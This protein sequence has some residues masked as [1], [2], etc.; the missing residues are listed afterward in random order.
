MTAD[1]LHR[2]GTKNSAVALHEAGHVSAGWA[3]RPAVQILHASIAPP[4]VRTRW[5]TDVSDE[6]AAT[7]E[8]LILID[9]AGG[10]AEREA[11][12]WPDCHAISADEH[13]ATA[14]AL[15][16][17]ARRHL[18]RGGTFGGGITGAMVAEAENLV[19]SLRPRAEEL[20]AANWPAVERVA[21]ALDQHKTLDAAAIEEIIGGGE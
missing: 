14:R 18:E 3:A 2:R 9:L 7:L 6:L 8:K 21:Q 20:V 12:Y 4:G 13:N 5:R 1:G 17:V 16:I 19:E 15:T 10:A 11:G